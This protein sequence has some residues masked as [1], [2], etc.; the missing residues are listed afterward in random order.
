MHQCLLRYKVPYLT[1]HHDIKTRGGVEIQL[2]AIL[3]SVASR[4]D[5]FIRGVEAW[6]PLDTDLGGLSGGAD[7]KSLP[8]RPA[9]SLVTIP[10]EPTQ[11]DMSHFSSQ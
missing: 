4:Q 6:S 11:P 5:S 9:R 2:H 10:T 7:K 8:G 1:K 3:N